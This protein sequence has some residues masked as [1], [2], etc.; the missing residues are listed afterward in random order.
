MKNKVTKAASAG[1]IKL[2]TPTLNDGLCL[3]VQLLI[4]L[5]VLGWA[6]WQIRTVNPMAFALFAGSMV[7]VLVLAIAHVWPRED[8]ARPSHRSSQHT[9]VTPSAMAPDDVLRG[10]PPIDG[11]LEV[12]RNLYPD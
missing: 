7:A 5:A 2:D 12:R 3:F 8:A 11:L 9:S 10:Y 1:R 4:F 6:T